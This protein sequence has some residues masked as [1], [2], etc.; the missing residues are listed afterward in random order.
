MGRQN[1][2]GIEVKCYDAELPA[3]QLDTS[4]VIYQHIRAARQVKNVRTDR[5]LVTL[6]HHGLHILQ[7][8]GTTPDDSEVIR[9]DRKLID[10]ATLIDI[11][12]F[13]VDALTLKPRED[14]SHHKADPV[15]D[16]EW[17]TID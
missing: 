5:G 12:R 2:I 3:A 17:M 11:C 15:F 6:I 13:K 14:R 16:E 10:K 4:R 7:F 1:M 9:W 8:S